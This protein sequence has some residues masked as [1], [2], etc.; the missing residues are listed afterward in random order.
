MTARL[1]LNLDGSRHFWFGGSLIHEKVKFTQQ[2]P[3]VTGN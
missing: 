3:F 1:D 2:M